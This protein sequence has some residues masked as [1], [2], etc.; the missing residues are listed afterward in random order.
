MGSGAMGR[1][2]WTG[3]TGRTTGGGRDDFS[4]AFSA[5]SLRTRAWSAVS[6][7]VSSASS[8]ALAF[9]ALTSTSGASDV[10][11]ALASSVSAFHIS[12]KTFWTSF[13]FSLPARPSLSFS[14]AAL[15]SARCSLSK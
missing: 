13:S 6:R 8:A 5:S 2:S 11:L 7:A 12:A 14:T 9:F 1:T 4:A 15:A 3:A 10:H